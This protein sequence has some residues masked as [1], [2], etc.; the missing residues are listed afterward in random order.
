MPAEPAVRYAC[1][2]AATGARPRTGV[3]L[4]VGLACRRCG[5][6]SRTRAHRRR[7]VWSVRVR[8]LRFVSVDCCAWAADRGRFEPMFPRGEGDALC[9]VG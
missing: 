4:H 5:P 3:D 6:V 1:R 8:K 7:F 9:L 2:A